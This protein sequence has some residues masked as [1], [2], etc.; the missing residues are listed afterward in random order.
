MIT[1]SAEPEW[2]LMLW[3]WDKGSMQARIE[4]N[5]PDSGIDLGSYMV[6]MQNI[7]T[8]NICV[9]TGPDTYLYLKIA[10]DYSNFDKY[11]SQLAKPELKFSTHFTCHTWTREV[12]PRLI[13]CTKAGEI[14]IC[15]S[16]GELNSRLQSSPFGKQIFTILPYGDGFIAAGENGTIWTYQVNLDSGV[17][18]SP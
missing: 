13:V 1:L 7:N 17:F 18:F 15:N 8:E 5:I 14:L 3:N 9:V 6:S 4:L 11:H 16:T 2:V 12:N 10:H